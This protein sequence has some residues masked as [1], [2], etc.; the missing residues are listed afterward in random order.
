MGYYD[1][2]S[3]ELI[4]ELCEFSREE[5][6]KRIKL[7]D[8]DL[9]MEKESR[10][11]NGYSME[12]VK[13]YFRTGC[14][15]NLYKNLNKSIIYFDDDITKLKKIHPYNEKILNEFF[16]E[17]R[18]IGIVKIND[19]K[20]EVKVDYLKASIYM[21][22]NIYVYM[23]NEYRNA[24][25]RTIDKLISMGIDR[26]K[27]LVENEEYKSVMPLL[28][29]NLRYIDLIFIPSISILKEYRYLFEF[30]KNLIDMEVDFILGEYVGI[31]KEFKIKEKDFLMD[32]IC[33]MLKLNEAHNNF[34]N[35]QDTKLEKEIN[36]IE[37]QELI[38]CDVSDDDNDYDTEKVA[39]ETIDISEYI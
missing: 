5:N 8:L 39:N 24:N 30:L 28:M 36:Q 6:N 33:N 26:S 38:D 35:S 13:D 17:L 32:Q 21:G 34:G 4:D 18:K 11:W 29:N 25:R 7:A 10:R 15:V 20:V 12:L 16:S 31:S 14:Y 27:I 23:D 1:Y 19:K 22:K 3:Y 9:L 2:I 37:E